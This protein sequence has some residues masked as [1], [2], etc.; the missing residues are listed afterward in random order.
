METVAATRSTDLGRKFSLRPAAALLV[1]RPCATPSPDLGLG[2]IYCRTPFAFPRVRRRLFSPRKAPP[3]RNFLPFATDGF[4]KNRNLAFCRN[5]SPASLAAEIRTVTT[6][7][8]L[9]N[10]FFGSN[11]GHVASV[12]CEQH[13]FFS[14]TPINSTQCTSVYIYTRLCMCTKIVKCKFS[15]VVTFGT[16]PR[17]RMRIPGP[18]P[19]FSCR[20]CPHVYYHRVPGWGRFA[21]V[22]SLRESRRFTP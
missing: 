21:P 17:G 11:Y 20:S 19:V 2:Q 18:F 13:R 22:R 8:R 6:T 9:Q 10:T 1:T 16:D 14:Q 12:L 7:R 15:L 5:G 4:R 3:V